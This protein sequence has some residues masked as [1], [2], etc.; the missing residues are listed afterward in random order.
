MIRHCARVS[1]RTLPR[2]GQAV[3]RRQTSAA[4][5][6]AAECPWDRRLEPTVVTYL[7]GAT[8]DNVN[9]CHWPIGRSADL[10]SWESFAR[11]M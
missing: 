11:T 6:R 3:V 7:C 8:S 9:P 1:A 2:H 10:D 5:V 4:A